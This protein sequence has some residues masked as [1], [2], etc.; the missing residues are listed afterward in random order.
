[1]L[2]SPRAHLGGGARRPGRQIAWQPPIEEDRFHGVPNP[3]DVS[4]HTAWRQSVL[5]GLPTRFLC[6]EDD[7]APRPPGSAQLEVFQR[8]AGLNCGLDRTTADKLR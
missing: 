2:H 8:Y 7:E 3:V 5:T 4:H 1:M 6:C